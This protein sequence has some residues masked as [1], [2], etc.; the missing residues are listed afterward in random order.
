MAFGYVR[1]H[2]FRHYKIR[3]FRSWGFFLGILS[4]RSCWSVSDSGSNKQRVISLSLSSELTASRDDRDPITEAIRLP[5]KAYFWTQISV[6]LPAALRPAV[7][8]IRSCGLTRVLSRSEG[9]RKE[10]ADRFQVPAAAFSRTRTKRSELGQRARQS[11]SVSSSNQLV[12]C[13]QAP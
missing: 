3:S 8:L 6:G 5:Q 12:A 9:P 10:T 4:F 1:H 13:V 2:A 11:K 7:D